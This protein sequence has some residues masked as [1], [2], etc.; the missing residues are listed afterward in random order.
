[1]NIGNESF[2][3]CIKRSFLY[4]RSAKALRQL[5]SFDEALKRLK[6]ANA[7]KPK[8]ER[9]CSEIEKVRPMPSYTCILDVTILYVHGIITV[10]RSQNERYSC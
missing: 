7:L 2:E 8:D 4:F 10:E 3:E 5:A 9:I 6:R 1:M